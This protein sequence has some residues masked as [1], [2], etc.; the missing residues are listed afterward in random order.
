MNGVTCLVMFILTPELALL[1]SLSDEAYGL[2]VKTIRLNMFQTVIFWPFAF[3][4]PNYLRAAGDA[5]F[6]MVVSIFSMWAFRVLLSRILGLVLGFGLMGVMWGMFI[7]WYFRGIVFTIR[8]LKGK[9]KTK[10]VV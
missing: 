4:I 7:D 3:T 1:Y 2:A 9:W 8:F 5:R 6:T 10:T